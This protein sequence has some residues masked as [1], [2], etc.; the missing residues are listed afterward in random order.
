MPKQKTHSAASKRF[1]FSAT[2]K[3]IRTR[4]HKKHK[5]TCKTTK[6][7][8]NLRGSAVASPADTKRILTLMPYKE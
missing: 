4:G 2:G 3:P 6:Q 7:K 5:A 8:R 1:K